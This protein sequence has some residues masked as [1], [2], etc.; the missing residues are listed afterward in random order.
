MQYMHEIHNAAQPQNGGR[1]VTGT[2]K[3]AFKIIWRVLTY[4]VSHTEF[5]FS[6]KL[7]GYWARMSG[8]KVLL[9]KITF[10]EKKSEIDFE[11]CYPV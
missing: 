9:R 5:E 11:T 3:I 8:F 2:P 7:G 4:V 6:I 10:F 1:S